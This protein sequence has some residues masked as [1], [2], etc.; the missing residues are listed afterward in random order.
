MSDPGGSGPPVHAG[1]LVPWA[2]ITVEAELHNW[3]GDTVVWHYARLVPS[4]RTTALDGQFMAGLLDAVPTAIDQVS[5][6]PVRHVYLACTSAAF[7]YPLRVQAAARHAKVTLVS[8]FDA[9]A[10]AL[11]ACRAGH[12]VLL[13]PYPEEVTRAEADMFGLI[14]ITVTGY[15]SL[16]LDDGYGEITPDQ[17]GGLTGK[18]SDTAMEKAEAIVLSCTGWRTLEVLPQL[19]RRLGRPV[20]SSN[21]AMALHARAVRDAW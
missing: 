4:S 19:Q 3:S 1:V 15:A 16:N 7:M 20:I 5:A 9:I 6:L 8:A 10:S 2:N 17:V 14:G 12:V 13:T 11:Q 21:L 18:V